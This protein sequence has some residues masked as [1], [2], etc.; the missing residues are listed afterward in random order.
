MQAEHMRLCGGTFFQLILQGVRQRLKAR[1][2]FAGGSDNLKDT[3]V[4]IGL[5]R[6]AQEDYQDPAI[7]T[8]SQ[9]TSAYKS[10]ELSHGTYLPFEDEAFISA[11]D[12]RIKNEYSTALMAMSRFVDTF[13][14]TGATEKHIRL[15]KA[16][17][18][19]VETDNSIANTDSFYV[20]QNGS[21]S[22]KATI[23]DM[24]DVCLPAFLLGIWH[25]IVLNRKDN[26]IGRDTFESW[27]E[28]PAVKGAKWIYNGHIGTGITRV[29]T[30]TEHLQTSITD[31]NNFET[32][33]IK[34]P[35]NSRKDIV[36]DYLRKG[37]AKNL[38]ELFEDAIDKYQIDKFVDSDYTTMPLYCNVFTE[39]NSFIAYMRDEFR[40]FRRKRDLTLENCITFV[41]ILEKYSFYLDTKMI[42]DDGEKLYWLQNLDW[43]TVYK[44]LQNYRQN[45]EKLYNRITNGRSLSVYGFPAFGDEDNADLQNEFTTTKKDRQSDRFTDDSTSKTT[46]QVIDNPIIFNQ[47]GNNNVQIAHVETLTINNDREEAKE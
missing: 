44:E 11:F 3:D 40:S 26:S 39:V 14:D 31:N 13:I 28:K 18:E 32:T 36:D 7:S 1:D 34:F 17:L 9:N 47:H 19:L 6:V 30:I 35:E 8:F 16:L 37:N 15:V 2:R 4:L 12:N 46:N 27:H 33:E 20:R 10:C 41:S 45:L 21:S 24:T 29:I 42:T 25:F 5:I 43:A 38:I 23:K 22:D